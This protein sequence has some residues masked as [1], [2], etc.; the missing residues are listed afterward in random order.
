MNAVAIGCGIAGVLVA[1]TVRIHVLVLRSALRR[2]IYELWPQHDGPSRTVGHLVRRFRD[3]QAFVRLVVR[4]RSCPRRP[5]AALA[6][7][8]D[9]VARTC[10]SG[11]TLAAAFSAAQASSA[12]QPLFERTVEALEL[13]ATFDEALACEQADD[14]DT[15]LAVHVLRLCVIQGGKVSESIDRAA[16]TLRE[17]DSTAQERIAQSAQA[18]IS[19]QLLTAVPIAFAIWTLSTTASMRQFVATPPGFICISL[20]IAFNVVGWTLMKRAI[21]GTP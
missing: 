6:N 9:S 19:A 3:A 17:R 4:K 10:S 20:G 14:P 15:A 12:D 11:Q 2:R 1:I 13:G 8:L 7:L 5:A 18:R 21:R 16:A